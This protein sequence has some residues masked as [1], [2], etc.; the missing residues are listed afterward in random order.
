MSLSIIGAGFGRTGTLSLKHA[1]EDLGFGPCYHM[2]EVIANPS[3]AALW[4]ALA[5]GEAHCLDRILEPYAATVDWPGAAYWRELV[6]LHPDAKVLLSLRDGESWHRSVMNTIFKAM[7]LELP[8]EAPAHIRVQLGMVRRLIFDGTFGGKL[9]DPEHAIEVFDA[10]NRSVIDAVPAERLLVYRPGDGWE[11]LC[12][13]LHV[14]V[15]D[16]DY[17]HVNSSEEFP[18]IFGPRL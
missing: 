6:S 12:Q 11:P 15:P 3:H 5:D 2:Q 7:S 16:H 9:E 14:P 10:H 8:E 17:P 1:L 13:F 4:A 18:T